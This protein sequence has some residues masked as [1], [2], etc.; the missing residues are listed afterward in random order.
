MRI[1]AYPTAGAGGQGRVVG[2]AG[3]EERR[4]APVEGQRVGPHPGVA[5]GQQRGHAA[6]IAYPEESGQRSGVAG[7]AAV[8]SSIGRENERKRNLRA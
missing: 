1:A 8:K 5:Q 3:V 7:G 2:A 4:A 6:G